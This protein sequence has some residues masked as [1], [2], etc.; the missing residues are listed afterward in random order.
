VP[1]G[2]HV[3]DT[4]TEETV[5]G[6]CLQVHCPLCEET[7]AFDARERRRWL[8]LFWT[9]VLPY[10]VDRTLQCP[11]CGGG[12]DVDAA[13]YELAVERAEALEG[14]LVGD[15]DGERLDAL[16]A[17]LEATLDDDIED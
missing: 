3:V 9:A 4:V 7:R 10:A 16:T 14:W 13:T 15:V 5:H 11:A 12:V 17:E 6:P 1:E 2:F 8:R